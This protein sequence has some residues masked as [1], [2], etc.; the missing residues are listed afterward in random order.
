[1][2]AVLLSLSLLVV[3]AAGA[4]SAQGYY[5]RVY[6]GAKSGSDRQSL[7]RPAGAGR[8]RRCRARG[9]SSPQS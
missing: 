4:A 2:R 8:A 5:D 9:Q 3:A 1:M 7:R 6:R